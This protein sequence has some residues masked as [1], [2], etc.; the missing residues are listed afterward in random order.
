MTLLITGLRGTVAPVVARRAA[1]QGL[2]VIGWNRDTTPPE[3]A[4]AS[5]AWLE[6][7]RPRYIA[8]LA[9]G[10]VEW[11]RQIALYSEKYS[12]PL[13]VT[14]TVSV[15]HHVPNGPHG[16]DDERN[17]PDSYGQ[18][19]R[20]CED[21]VLH[22][23]PAA[24]VARLGWQ[25]DAVQPGNNMLVA[26]DRWQVT[27]GRVAASRAW[28]PACSFMEDT[29]DAILSLLLTRAAGVRH[30]DSNADEGHN[31]ASIVRALKHVFNRNSWN[32][33]EHEEYV[34]DQRLGG[35][36]TLVPPL[37]ARLPPLMSAPSAS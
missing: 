35:G 2:A 23:N 4:A 20:E 21:A 12:V 14:S 30:I 11:A 7:Q 29:A 31:F 10:S 1:A 17:S 8:H 28:R 6:S 22:A 26:L 34:H 19:K 13:V 9:T 36:G 25:I 18:Y 32:I 5:R 33:H 24:C 3:D 37:S 15:F 16:V 27:E